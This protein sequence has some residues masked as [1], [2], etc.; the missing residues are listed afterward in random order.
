MFVTGKNVKF[1]AILY[2]EKNLPEK[3][4]QASFTLM[5]ATKEKVL[6]YCNC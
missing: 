3:K 4:K 1:A 2:P 6:Y 5:S